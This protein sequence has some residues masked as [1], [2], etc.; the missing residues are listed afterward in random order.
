MRGVQ[1]V[2]NVH[3]AAVVTRKNGHQDDAVG[4]EKMG[5]WLLAV[6]TDVGF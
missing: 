6:G 4:E 1:I 5:N 3:E 2:T